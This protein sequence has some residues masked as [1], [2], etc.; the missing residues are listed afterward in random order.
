MGHRVRRSGA[1]ELNFSE[2]CQF[3]QDKNVKLIYR[4]S[5][6]SL[7]WQA[8]QPSPRVRAKPELQTL[9]G[10]QIAGIKGSYIFQGVL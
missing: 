4:A 2:Y 6:I 3:L 8:E 7:Q 5:S 10:L 9:K 1:P